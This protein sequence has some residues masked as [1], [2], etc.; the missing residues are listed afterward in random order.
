MNEVYFEELWQDFLRIEDKDG[1]YG[2]VRRIQWYVRGI[3]DQKRIAFL[4]ELVSVG[5]EKKDGWSIALRVL[6]SEAMSQHIQALCEWVRRVRLDGSHAE[7]NFISV[8]R[9]LASDPTGQCLAAVED[10]L[11]KGQVDSDWA[12][13]P[14]ALWPHHPDLFARAWT[15]YFLSPPNREWRR[16]GPV[17]ALLSNAGALAHLKS[18]LIVV[19]ES[20]WQD[21]RN[22]LSEQRN[23]GWLSDDQRRA[24]AEVLDAGSVTRKDG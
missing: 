24:L 2:N 6:E 16:L 7:G 18:K 3:S 9:V 13:L 12:T 17:Q 10:Y 4:S 11:L 20:V 19:S 23:A 1:G 21:L 8:L 15:R 5:L 22:V 14:W